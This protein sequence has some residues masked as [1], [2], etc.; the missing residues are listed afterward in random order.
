MSGFGI[1]ILDANEQPKDQE[2]FY[3]LHKS[4]VET[5]YKTVGFIF[6]TK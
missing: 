5:V 2:T 3:K 1:F 4:V 6:I